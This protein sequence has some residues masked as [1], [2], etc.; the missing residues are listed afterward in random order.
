MKH[1]SLILFLCLLPACTA[2]KLTYIWKEGS[3]LSHHFSKILV[4]AIIND[5]DNN[6]K[7]RLEA[8]IT[9]DLRQLGYN[10]IPAMH[11]YGP[12]HFERFSEF[13]A[14]NQIRDWGFDAVFTVVLINKETE[15]LK[16]NS[17]NCEP[18]PFWAYMS[19]RLNNACECCDETMVTNY[20][21]ESNFYEME[22]LNLLYS[23]QTTSFAAQHVE[24]MSH[25]YGRVIVKNM[26]KNGILKN[27]RK[28][29]RQNLAMK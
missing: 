17:K 28:E 21:W 9:E 7:D 27:I 19:K 3:Y 15:I 22:N 24:S 12:K 1:L 13:G 25:Q 20:F 23:A 16:S 26:V 6:I 2:T 5:K 18:Q 10:A 11:T 14:V 29:N 4:L 8:H